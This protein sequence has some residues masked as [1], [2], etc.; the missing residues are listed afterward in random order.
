[1]KNNKY[2]PIWIALLSSFIVMVF[3]LLNI[4]WIFAIAG[5]FWVA[6]IGRQEKK[7]KATFLYL[8]K[9]TFLF[10]VCFS[11]LVLSYDVLMNIVLNIDTLSKSSFGVTISHI[12]KT[13]S[14]LEA[15]ES[16]DD[17]VIKIVFSFLIKFCLLS[18]ISVVLCL[19]LKHENQDNS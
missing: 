16:K 8:L 7:N 18:I 3:N 17:F 12:D 2:F 13:Q 15:E 10:C 19:F 9:K 1:M 11:L 14:A 4:G 5:V 6:K